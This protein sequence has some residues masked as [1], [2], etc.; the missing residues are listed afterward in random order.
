MKEPSTP[1]S[2]Q[3]TRN[4]VEVGPLSREDHGLVLSCQANNNNLA[5][6]LSVDAVIDMHC[7]FIYTSMYVFLINRYVNY[8]YILSYF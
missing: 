6:P 1:I 2:D 7:K 4:D 5:P 8:L 3:R